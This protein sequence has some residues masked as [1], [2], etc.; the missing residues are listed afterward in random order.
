MKTLDTGKSPGS[1]DDRRFPPPPSFASRALLDSAGVA[2][3][4]SRQRRSRGLLA[5]QAHT[6]L[7]WRRPRRGPDRKG[8]PFITW[9]AD[10]ELNLTES[11]LTVT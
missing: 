6:P 9:F 5:D 7:E 8:A 3:S 10:G 4:T 2:A 11:C 1:P